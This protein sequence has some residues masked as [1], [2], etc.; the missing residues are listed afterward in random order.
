M[1]QLPVTQL[2]YGDS[3]ARYSWI[4]YTLGQ[5]RCYG[6]SKPYPNDEE[7]TEI[8]N[9]IHDNI[10]NLQKWTVKYDPSIYPRFYAMGD[11]SEFTGVESI[12]TAIIY[13]TIDYNIGNNFI[14]ETGVFNAPQAGLYEFIFNLK[15]ACVAEHVSHSHIM[16]NN[17]NVSAQTVQKIG[18]HPSVTHIITLSLKQNDEVYTSIDSKTCSSAAEGQQIYFQGRLIYPY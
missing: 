16:H 17:K 18:S 1:E 10:K 14:N 4:Y 13:K 9:E 8:F 12:T 5:L 2:N 6:K 3:Q 15:I 7:I 11:G